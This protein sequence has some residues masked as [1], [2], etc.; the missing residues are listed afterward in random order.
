MEGMTTSH[1]PQAPGRRPP[2]SRARAAVPLL[3]AGWLVLEIWLLTVVARETSPLLVLLLLLAGVVVGGV[4]VKRAGLRAWRNL[5]AAV[6]GGGA[7]DPAPPRAAPSGA[8]PSG[9]G[10]SAAGLSGAGLSGAGLAMLGGA[11]LILPGLASDAL[12][13]L[14]LF[15][16]TRAALR[17]AGGAAARRRGL[18]ASPLGDA[19]QQAQAAGEHLRIHRP[20]GKIVPGEVIRQDRTPRPDPDG[21]RPP[22]TP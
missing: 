9:G 20:D 2:R 8:A 16:P 14:C 22:L 18:A 13:L 17:K 19:Y 7:A 10:S 4:V 12:G 3:L 5:T 1:A 21:P 15:P 6:Q 11:L